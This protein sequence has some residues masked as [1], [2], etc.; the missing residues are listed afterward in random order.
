M[1]N[2]SFSQHRLSFLFKKQDS[3][4]LD[5]PKKDMASK[6]KRE[7][8]PVEHKENKTSKEKKQKLV[9][10]ELTEQEVQE[11]KEARKNRAEAKE[12][13]NKD[14]RKRAAARDTTIFE[15]EHSPKKTDALVDVLRN[16]F[17]ESS[18]LNEFCS[19]DVNYLDFAS[20]IKDHVLVIFKDTYKTYDRKYDKYLDDAVFK[21]I[22]KEFHAVFLPDD[23]PK[24][25]A[26]DTSVED[27]FDA[28][29]DFF[30]SPEDPASAD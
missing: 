9:S 12:Q 21:P 7:D 4:N 22:W 25:D 20:F 14:K 6:R 11:V 27:A 1:H 24:S 10:M 2:T 26:L 30:E 5:K 29:I 8:V 18:L 28:M 13:E 15:L 16:V 19:V 17:V 3:H 23:A